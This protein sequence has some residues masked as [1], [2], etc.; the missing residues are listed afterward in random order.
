MTVKY[1]RG[2]N[3]NWITNANWSLTSGGPADTT[4][5]TAGDA[6]IFDSNS[7]NCTLDANAACDSITA[8]VAGGY[9]G[10][11]V[12]TGFDMDV[13]GNCELNAGTWT[14]GSGSTWN[15]AGGMQHASCTNWIGDGATINFDGNGTFSWTQI[16][17]I[18]DAASHI[19]GADVVLTVSVNHFYAKNLDVYGQITTAAASKQVQ[20]LSG[21]LT[22]RAGS[23]ITQNNTYISIENS[24]VALMDGTFTGVTEL[25]FHAPTG[26]TMAPGTY[27]CDVVAM[28]YTGSS[29][30]AYTVSSVSGTTNINGDLWIKDGAGNRD[31]KFTNVSGAI[32][33]ISGDL[34]LDDISTISDGNGVGIV[35]FDNSANNQT[36]TIS[37]DMTLTT[38]GTGTVTFTKSA[39]GGVIDFNSAGDQNVDALSE[40]VGVITI[41]KAGTGIID[42]QSGDFALGANSS[43]YGLTISGDTELDVV[44]F[45]LAIGVGGFDGSGG[46]AATVLCGVG[47]TW[48]C[49]GNFD[50]KDIGTWTRETSHVVL[51]GT[52]KIL[53]GHSDNDFHDL[54]FATGSSITVSPSTTNRVDVQGTLTIDGT[55]T[56][57]VILAARAD[58]DI[59]IGANAVIGGASSLRCF[60]ST[61]GHGITDVHADATL[62]CNIVF[63]NTVAGTRCVP[64]TTSGIFELTAF[65]AENT[66]LQLDN[67]GDYNFGAL[68][69]DNNGT[70]LITLD[71]AT[72][73]PASITCGNLTCDMAGTGNILVDGTDKGTDWT[74]TGDVIQ[75]EGSSGRL[76]WTPGTGDMTFSDNLD[77]DIDFN[78][79]T[80]EAITITKAGTGII[81]LQSGDFELGANSSMYGLAISGD[82]DLDAVTFDLAIGASGLD[83]EFGGSAIISMGSGTWTV[84][85]GTFDYQDIGTL[86]DDSST[87]VFVG[88]CS[89][90]AKTNIE[91]RTVNIA[92][93]GT[94]TKTGGTAIVKV[95]VAVGNDAILLCNT[96]VNVSAAELT[97]GTNSRVGGVGAIVMSPVGSGQGYT[98][99]GA[100]TTLDVALF[101]MRPIATSPDLPAGVYSSAVVIYNSA[102]NAGLLVPDSGAYLFDS[103]ELESRNDTGPLTLDLKTNG[104]TITVAGELLIDID[105]DA[106][107]TVDNNGGSGKWVLQGNVNYDNAGAGADGVLVWNAGGGSSSMLLSGTNAQNVDF[108]GQTVEAITITKASGTVTFGD[109]FTTAAFTGGP[110]ASI[111]GAVLIT[112]QGNFA[113]NGTSGNEITFNG[114]DLDVT[115][116]A[117]AHFTTATNSD[118]SAGTKVTATDNC[119]DG[120]GNT[121]WLF[122]HHAAWYYRAQEALAL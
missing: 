103:L 36:M 109:D 97:T 106:D 85:G 31:M 58:C 3:S 95:L 88:V 63:Q 7:G 15:V 2:N 118:A 98:S 35:E 77:Q 52:T 53:T 8:S 59:V 21:T 75:I 107:I 20:L 65:G 54:T 26:E 104:P 66:L 6:V 83:C 34:K 23:N 24:S 18:G 5:P 79:Q 22:M 4:F 61:S 45:D 1:Y 57:N 114:P 32:L 28:T 108:N 14:M 115:G 90:I 38:L 73:G 19:I 25:R 69:F 10:S 16:N 87:I 62:N 9:A 11:F 68:L 105:N 99:R 94:T 37:G 30:A 119:V 56:L 50:N 41:T 72:N 48:T 84:T 44:T 39:A 33:N 113:L 43:M 91:V 82:T 100:G 40:D 49:D 74:I 17:D 122:A 46:A 86:N 47:S 120:T 89:W 116:T 112:V 93:N 110:N 80:V 92:N 111:T 27:D 29:T 12:A 51:T 67:L 70:G 71:N 121:N 64:L 42:L 13:G 78:G 81:D 60:T 102:A 101:A 96:N 117:V 76:T 55:V